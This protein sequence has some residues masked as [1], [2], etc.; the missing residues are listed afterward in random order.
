MKEAS[1]NLVMSFNDCITRRDLGG[2]SKLMTDDHAFIDPANSTIAGKPRCV[3]AW[4][5]FFAAFPDYRNHFERVLLAGSDVVII[6]HS[7]CS[8]ARLAGPALWTAK[9]EGELIAEWRVYE[10]TDTNRALLGLKD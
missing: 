7:V 3:E 6:G 8:D 9:L 10:D 4:R 1:A 2:L 5:G